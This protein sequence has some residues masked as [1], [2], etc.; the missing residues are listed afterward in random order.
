MYLFTFLL[1][2]LV[3]YLFSYLFPYSFIYLLTYLLACAMGGNL[4]WLIGVGTSANSSTALRIQLLSV[5]N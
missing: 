1:T 4:V 3:I 5:D 2:Y